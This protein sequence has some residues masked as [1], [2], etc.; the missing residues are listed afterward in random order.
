[1]NVGW[2]DRATPAHQPRCSSNESKVSLRSAI[3]SSGE[4]NI[5]VACG[6]T[7]ENGSFTGEGRFSPVKPGTRIISVRRKAN[8]G[9]HII[10]GNNEVGSS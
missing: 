10:T 7:C 6:C 3:P 8:I 9:G 1:M 4:N 5:D 2:S